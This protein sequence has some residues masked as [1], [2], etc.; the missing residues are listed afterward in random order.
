MRHAWALIW[1]FST[2]RSE[3]MSNQLQELFR[4]TRR[5]GENQTKVNL[6]QTEFGRWQDINLN[7]SEP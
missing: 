7:S 6:I 2:M 3:L 1:S 4:R 5:H